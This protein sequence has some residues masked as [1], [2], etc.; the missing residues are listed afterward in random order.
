MDV[1][2]DIIP[3]QQ[4]SS[5]DTNP[6]VNMVKPE[7]RCLWQCRLEELKEHKLKTGIAHVPGAKKGLA[8]WCLRQRAQY[9]QYLKG[10]TVPLNED[11]IKA[12]NAV[13]FVWNPKY[14]GQ[15]GETSGSPPS[16][17][18]HQKD[19]ADKC[20]ISI[21]CADSNLET[22]L[23]EVA[24]TYTGQ[25]VSPPM[26]LKDAPIDDGLRD[27]VVEGGS[28]PSKTVHKKDDADK[29]SVS[30]RCADSN[31]ESPLKEVAQ[32]YTGQIVSPPMLLKD[33]PVDDGLRD[34]VV[35]GGSP[36][37]K[38]VHQKDDADKCS[39]S[40]RCADSNLESSLR[41]VAQTYIGQIVSPPMLLK[42]APVDN[43]LRDLVV[44]GGSPPSKTV[45]QKD[46]AN[47][48]SIS[49]RSAD[50]NLETP[51][52][53]V[54]QTYTGQ[55]VSPPMLLK[56][57]PVDNGLRDL[58]V[59]GGSP[60][61][62]TVHQKDDAN[63]CSISIRCADSNLETPLKEVA[64]TDTGQIVSPPMLLKDAPVD[65]GLRD[66]VVEG[67]SPPSKTVHQ[68]DDANM[69][70]IS[71]RCA[72]S[73]LETPLR[74]VA[75]TYTGQI[76]SAPMLL[77]DAPVDNGLRDLLVKG[78][79]QEYFD[80]FQESGI[81]SLS[82]LC[83]KLEDLVFMEKLVTDV[84]FTASQAIRFQMLAATTA[85]ATTLPCKLN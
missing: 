83:D 54:A 47:M 75:Q 46:D 77:K 59:E 43:G 65:N 35:E 48:C 29:C 57:A 71:I 8:S 78:Q 22:P 68:K 53:E 16:K 19:D 11:R 74:E 37:S 64:Q 1:N 7:R 60:P 14:I 70:S 63:M 3:S 30:I 9:R 4:E 66:L 20:S 27:L 58:V 32:T 26:L 13:G 61:S 84:G 76:V 18:V 40:I 17:T 69:C 28:P 67:G 42:D 38:T 33:A 39:V 6:N 23:K 31:L 73:N 80:K 25:I 56:D 50:S 10:V 45:H 62:K 52:K 41:E 85:H 44:E 82:D 79:L 51:L 12:L 72:D 15:F 24:Q 21:R 34:L 81:S 36:P 55:I 49:I 5:I 2:K